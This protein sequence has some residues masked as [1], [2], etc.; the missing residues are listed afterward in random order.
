[1]GLDQLQLRFQLFGRGFFEGLKSLLNG[2]DEC[3]DGAVFFF[4]KMLTDTALGVGFD[5][6]PKPVDVDDDEGFV[7][8][9]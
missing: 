1:M 3:E 5:V 8:K 9:L 7:V 6:I 4:D 2:I